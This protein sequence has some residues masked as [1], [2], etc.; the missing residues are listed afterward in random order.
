MLMVLGA[1]STDAADP[2]CR[3][4]YLDHE[5]WGGS[6]TVETCITKMQPNHLWWPQQGLVLRALELIVEPAAQHRP[7]RS[8][9]SSTSLMLWGEASSAADEMVLL[10]VFANPRFW[11][12]IS[13]FLSALYC[14]IAFPCSYV[15][16]LS[17][18]PKRA[19]LFCHST[20]RRK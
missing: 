1:N 9:T 7:R 8:M 20:D 15:Y 3:H 4:N 5:R 17:V 14:T 18:I 10:R 6:T 11:V 12:G 13:N 19:G 2:C 16:F